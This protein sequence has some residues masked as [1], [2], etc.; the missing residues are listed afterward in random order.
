MMSREILIHG[1][2]A[3]GKRL[4]MQQIENDYIKANPKATIWRWRNGS[5][6]IEEYAGSNLKFKG[7][8]N[9]K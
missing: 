8:V 6:T 2:R 3:A 5:I 9:T 4:L 1:G 7:Q